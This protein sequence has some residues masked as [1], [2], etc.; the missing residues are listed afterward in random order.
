MILYVTLLSTV[1]PFIMAPRLPLRCGNTSKVLAGVSLLS[2]NGFLRVVCDPIMN[3]AL[4]T[5][6]GVER[7]GSHRTIPTPSLC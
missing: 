2:V 3:S 4:A 5:C 7:L 6:F 1:V